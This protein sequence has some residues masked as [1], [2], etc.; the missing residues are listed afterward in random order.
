MAGERGVRMGDRSNAGWF[1][2]DSFWIDQYPLM[3]SDQ[4]FVEAS[5]QVEQL[6][7]TAGPET[8]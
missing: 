8:E 3:F 2:D 4:R 6:V 7:G 5:A 1:D